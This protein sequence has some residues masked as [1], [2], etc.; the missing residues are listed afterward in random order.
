MT[1]TVEE[2]LALRNGVTEGPWMAAARPSSIVGWPVVGT[3]QGRSICSVTVHDEA[4]A[5]ARAIA[6]VPELFDRLDE[7]RAEI[8]R[9]KTALTGLLAA[10]D[11]MDKPPPHGGIFPVEKA[12]VTYAA[13]AALNGEDGA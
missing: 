5:N 10:V 1:R 8:E 2:L 6:A 11:Q 4:P 13:R 3:R 12:M 7:Q 9:L